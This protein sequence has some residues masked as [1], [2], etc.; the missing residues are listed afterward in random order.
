[1]FKWNMADS[2]NRCAPSPSEGVAKAVVSAAS[3]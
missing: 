2:T 1:M 3:L